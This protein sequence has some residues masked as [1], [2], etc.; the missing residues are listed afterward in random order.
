MILDQ[1]VFTDEALMLHAKLRSHLL[2]M[3]ITKDRWYSKTFFNLFSCMFVS[4]KLNRLINT[5]LLAM[6]RVTKRAIK[7][8]SDHKLF[9]L[10]LNHECFHTVTTCSFSTADQVNR[11]SI[12]KIER[13][14]AERTL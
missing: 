14:L 10:A 7:L 2:G 4:T 3:N 11:L 9:A 13:K 8:A 12:F 5:F 6:I 1:A